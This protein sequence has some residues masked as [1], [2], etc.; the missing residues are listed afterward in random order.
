MHAILSVRPDAIFVQSESS[1]YFHP[2]NPKAL[3]AAN[4]WNERRFLTLDL[5]YGHAVNSEMYQFLLD[6][7]LTREDYD[8]FMRMHLTS[9]CIMGNDYYVTNEHNITAEGLT[10]RSGEIFGYDEITRQYYQR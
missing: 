8:F 7:G 5:N 3:H 4:H 6:N 10:S 2:N 1:E 9:H